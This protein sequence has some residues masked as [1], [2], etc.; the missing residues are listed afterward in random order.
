[1]ART[2]QMSQSELPSIISERVTSRVS[3]LD[4]LRVI[5][6]ISVVVLHISARVVSS[7]SD[8]TTYYWWTG[9]IVDSAVRW[10]L[11]I[12]VMI[13]GFL[14]L[15]PQRQYTIESFYKTRISK[16]LIPLVFWTLFYLILVVIQGHI[17]NQPISTVQLIKRV[18]AGSPY[19]H[20]W[21][22]Y[23]LLSLIIFT[24]FIRKLV[25]ALTPRQTT[26][27]C[28]LVFVY[29]IISILVDQFYYGSFSAFS[30][31]N[32]LF[33]NWF[34]LYLGYYLV[35]YLLGSSHIRISPYVLWG[36][37]ILTVL[38]TAIGCY[39][40]SLKSGIDTGLYFYNYLSPLVILMSL[41]IFFIFK[42]HESILAKNR[43]IE[44]LSSCTLGIYLIHPFV[45]WVLKMIGLEVV[46]FNPIL[47]I[48]I[49]GFLVLIISIGCIAVISNIPYV[50]RII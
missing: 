43:F 10:S 33:I 49:M 16:L 19:F 3:Y 47:G 27:L 29:A 40:L 45:I 7:N 4:Y 28:T 9:N 11:P 34:L 8:F 24:P 30:L 15:Q 1:M 5:A 23:M 44:W 37:F 14:L 35:G 38:G 13:S 42:E 50:K 20:M 32:S 22:L 36:V 31:G 12:F 26:L 17:E 48:P 21:Y 18:L 2:I 41:S 46:N 39:L 25:E 6:A